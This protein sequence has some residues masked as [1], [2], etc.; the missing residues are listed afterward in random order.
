MNE[1]KQKFIKHN[2][3]KI[4]DIDAHSLRGKKFFHNIFSYRRK[5]LKNQQKRIKRL[6]DFECNLCGHKK[7][8]IFLG[9]KK[10]YKLVQCSKCSAVSPNI[11]HENEQEFIDSIYNNPNYTKKA[12]LDIYKNYNYRKKKFGSER[13]NYTINR[14]KLK[15]KCK[16]LDLGCG[17]GYYI[18]YLKSKGIDCKGIEPANNIAN[19]C[20]KEL[21]INV[22]SNKLHEEKNKYYDLITLFDVIEHLKNPIQYFK[23]INKKLKKGGYCVIYTPNIHSFGYAMMGSDQNTMLPFEHVCFFNQK[24]LKYLTNKTNF[25]IHSIETYGF[26][27]MDYF[28]YREFKDKKNYMNKVQGFT[29]LIQS[30]LDRNN[31]S[32][33]FR[34]T[35][36]N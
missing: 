16:V 3:L 10:N 22:S 6:K 1:Y 24:S 21:K 26:D 27:V 12:F 13:Y 35:L 11:S 8:N 25:K 29:N 19:F 33:H 31:L 32:N 28:L 4:F 20:K 15:K 36:K 5:I 34:I 30:I 7:G 18:N 14:L 9:W 23:I 17:F 2:N